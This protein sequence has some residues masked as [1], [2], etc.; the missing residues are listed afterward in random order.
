MNINIVAKTRAKKTGI[1]K[2][3]D[4]NYIVAVVEEPH[5][6]KAN[7]A[8]IKALAKY[9]HVAQSCI[10]I[11]LGKTGKKKTVIIN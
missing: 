8:I 7:A 4:K 10:K 2:I 9:F 11:K 6:G 5:D 1:T 3:N